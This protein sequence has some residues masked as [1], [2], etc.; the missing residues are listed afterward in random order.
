MRLRLPLLACALIAIL[1]SVASA[2]QERLAD[3]PLQLLRVGQDQ[4][5][6]VKINDAIYQAIGFGNTFMVTTSEGNVIIDTSIAFNAQRHKQLLQAENAGPIKYIILTHAHGDHTGG[7]GVWKEPS[8]QIIAQR[9][10]VEFQNYQTRLASFYARRNAAQFALRIPEPTAWAGNYGAKIQP[11][12]LFDDKYEFTLGGVKFEIFH[13][14]GE[15]YD[16][17]TVWIPKY[18]AAF[19]G[20]N[21]Y[22][23]FPNIYTLRGTE[24]RWALDYINSL[25]K[26]MSLN[27]E[28]VL[29]SHGS[30]VFGNAEITRRLT[31]YRNAIQY[32]H[33]E[34][35][36]GMNA[37]KDVYTLMREIRL[38]PELEVGESYGKLTWSIRGIY[39]G[40]VGWFD[41]N[42][43]SMYETPV[44]A[45]YPDIVKLAGGPAAVARLARDKIQE[46]KPVEALHLADIALAAE[47]A[48]RSALEA[49]LAALTALRD[50]CRNSNERG[51]LEHG[52]SDAKNKLK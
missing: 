41:G 29:P 31:K 37:G 47:P 1:P 13:T 2:Q 9:N 30:A 18:K 14:P 20:D 43:S 49:K 36:K 45:V 5:K 28:I 34:V 4:K 39:E 12:I 8:T 26:V 3:N 52:I 10:H 21:Y 6:A 33:D 42:P 16:H 25:N 15:T 24:P 38:P 50:R 35:V 7:I 32:V 23:S 17:L 51:W 27:P 11:T 48:D 19:T 22:E 40:Y 46:G 44:S